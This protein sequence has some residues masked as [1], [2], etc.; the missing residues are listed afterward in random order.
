MKLQHILPITLAVVLSACTTTPNIPP[1]NNP[2]LDGLGSESIVAF[3]N[4]RAF[5]R[6]LRDVA[7][8]ARPYDVWWA[9]NFNTQL[10]QNGCENPED[11]QDDIVVTTASR[12][13]S[14]SSP[15]SITNT[16]NYGVDE[17]DIVKQYKNFLI[18][19]QD[20]RLFSVDTGETNADLALTH[21]IDVYQDI[22]YD[23]WYD[24]LLVF[25]NLLLVTGYSYEA[26]ATE[27][28][29]FEISE[30]GKFTHRSTFYKSSDDYYDS[31]N[32]ATRLVDDKLI[33]YTPIDLTEIDIDE[34]F[35]W[36]II[37][38]WTGVTDKGEPWT[39][40][41][42]MFDARNI[43]YPV[44][45]S[46]DPVLHTVSVC[47]LDLKAD[48][49]LV[50]KTKGIVATK[51]SEW[52]VSREAAFIWATPSYD[53]LEFD[54]KKDCE[55]ETP[56]GF[57][58]A[59][60]SALYQFPLS[61]RAPT[62]MFTR[63]A[64][65]DQFSLES[66]GKSFKALVEW[67]ETGCYPQDDTKHLSYF[68]RKLSR[69]SQIPPRAD[70]LHYTDVPDF[71][72]GGLE[73]RF[74]DTH[75]VYAGRKSRWDRASSDENGPHLATV[76]ADEN[77]KQPVQINIPHSVI[78]AERLGDGIIL[79][80]HRENEGLYVSMLSLDPTPRRTDT[81]L[82]EGRYESE[83]RSHAFNGVTYP[84]GSALMGLPTS[85]RV[86]D[87]RRNYWR[88]EGS[89]LS[90][91]Q[92]T[93]DGSLSNAGAMAGPEDDKVHPDYNCEMSCVDWYGNT[94]P[95]FLNGRIFGLLGTDL[96]EAK[97][98]GNKIRELSRIDLSAPLR[99]PPS[100]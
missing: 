74:T 19:L 34:P 43:Y 7:A 88:S 73:N 86:M 9:S 32:Y 95:V 68:K 79:T 71:E 100:N 2:A 26:D 14:S 11:C 3:E 96:L 72:G 55:D 42:N 78:R 77:P 51:D 69:F 48:E 17:G 97:I 12:S 31:D 24:E 52:Y 25:D 28:A 53:D 60:P 65:I 21:R 67:K 80:G 57:S 6:Y 30:T 36:P 91:M 37:R 1:V 87:S 84:D 47:P 81:L 93:P 20:G 49:A 70:G 59:R 83:G 22:E 61:G 58:N 50:C 33:L 5:R 23:A 45:R 44:Q 16:Q 13:S 75:L 92:A 76:I 85:R 89:D 66:D 46:I 82:V 35:R 4:D 54:A 10:A 18:V 94:R 99:E 64:P 39:T 15:T 62:A 40:G 98:T 63:G 56:V 29:V 41:K 27:L 8:K 38:K 90:F